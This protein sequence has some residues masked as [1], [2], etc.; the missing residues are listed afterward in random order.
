MFAILVLALLGVRAY[1][2]TPQSI[3]PTMSFS[4]I[5]VVAEAGDLPPDQVRI[6][7]TRPLEEAFQSLPS[8]TSVTSTSS[9]G[10]AELVVAFDAKTD[11]R[12]DLQYVDQATSE[13]RGGIS[14][15][16]NITAVIVNPNSEPVLSYAL[17]SPTLSQA[18]LREL[19]VTSLVPK[20]YG[21]QGMGRLLV[22]GGP[23]TEFHVDLDPT[24]LAAQGLGAADVTKAL[25]DANDVQAVGM[26]QRNY[27]Q[28][29]VIVDASLHDVASLEK[30]TIPVKT[31]GAVPLASLGRVH[32]GVSPVT[33]QTSLD[34]RHA[35]I[36]NAYGLP[37][38][39]TVKMAAQLKAKLA[40]AATRL[41]ADVKVRLFWDQT[42]LIVES[43]KALRDAI[44][45]GALLAIIVIYAF[46]RSL[47]LTLVAAAMIPLAMAIA[48]FALQMAGLTLNLMSVGG[49]AVAVGLIIDDAIVVIENIE[50]NARA[51][52]G[53]TIDENITRAMAQLGSAMIAS[54]ATTVVVFLP[55]ALLTGVT[56]FFFR[57]LAFTLAASLIVSLGLAL[58]LAPIMARTLL[59]GGHDAKPRKR[60]LVSSV[61]DRYEPV[62]RWTLGH[63]AAVYAGAA[64]VLVVT[65]VLLARLPSD[66]LPKMDE[67]QFE[68][69][70]ALP[71]GT[72]L[73]ASDAAASAMERVIA[74]DPAVAAVGRLTG[75]DSNGYSPTQPSQGLL[76]VRLKPGGQ[77]E[78]YEVVSERLRGNL[79]GAVPASA[80]DFHQ[81]LEDIINGLSGTP[82]PVEVT[83]H[84]TDQP[85]LIALANTVKSAISKV[86]GV[87]D[88]SP[89]V[90]YDSP[91][92]RIA[93]Q[94]TRLA[95]LGVSSADIGDAVS[96]QTQGTVATSVAGARNL[97]P[98][99]VSVAASG[100]SNDF[101]STPLLAKGGET[102]LGDLANINRVRLQSD[103]NAINGQSVVRV[104]A[105]ISGANLSAVTAGIDRALKATPFPPGYGGEIGGQAATQSQ[106]FGEFLSVIA[107]AVALVFA[108]MLATFRSFRL[109]LVILTAIPLALIGVALG[110][111]VTGTPFNVSSFM[112]LLLLV[113]V[114]VKNGILLI[115]V[116]NKHL[117]SGEPVEDALVAAG[118]TRLRPIVMTTLAA[119]GGLIPLAL[120]LGQGAEMERPLAIA[121]IGGLS[122][123]TVF[124]L[125][126]IPTLYAAFVGK[127]PPTSIAPE[128]LAA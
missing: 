126:V 84:G 41:P 127:K 77:R 64:S 85:K 92:L 102:S 18:V 1:L 3:F 101:G 26:T 72:T 120:G 123:A 34:G 121:V 50:R 9:Q 6:A 74:A 116:A 89:G 31:G 112:G 69:A 105:N 15:A 86:P 108:V 4:R 28:Y 56:G 103:I 57:A 52:P 2:V 68:I 63:R 47:R 106:S 83:I 54:T 100:A 99:R 37:G 110:L 71:V 16:K 25:A 8:V 61:L 109:P 90:V 104:T 35:V 38:A 70:Y 12:I 33:A 79:S 22:T 128:S 76:R 51:H 32:L 95:A 17:T 44:M 58:L 75:V 45:L 39:D 13:A 23:A 113:G 20:L 60:D 114:V 107:I 122:T 96:A 97:V 91:S 82:A 87:V 14:A 49:L 73:A 80:F 62:L 46:L 21:V 124:T 119:I 53:A 43:Q 88:A 5:D 19:A 125:L 11:P 78:N 81:I 40:G 10:S 48:L 111:F 36:V 27:Q 115:D 30:V 66:F 55:L 59:R 29:A 117:Q 94:G 98:V 7:V 67:G 118:K 42:T 65:V 24:A 93:P